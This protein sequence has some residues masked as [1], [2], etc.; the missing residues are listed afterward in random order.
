MSPDE[1]DALLARLLE[2]V[3][4]ARKSTTDIE[5]NI[6]LVTTLQSKIDQL[7]KSSNPSSLQHIAEGQRLKE[8]AS[9][10]LKS[11][12]QARTTQLDYLETA[13]QL[14]ANDLKLE[15]TEHRFAEALR[16]RAQL[17]QALQAQ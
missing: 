17:E 13:T 10:H 11:F 2:V 4:Q 12:L 3:S 16:V 7:S 8:T 15:W 14:V 5:E 9:N 1:L 6:T